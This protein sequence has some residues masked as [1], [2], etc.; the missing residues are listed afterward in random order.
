MTKRIVTLLLAVMFVLS[1]AACGTTTQAPAKIETP[2]ETKTEVKTSEPAPETS[3]PAPDTSTPAP[4]TP[5]PVAVEEPEFDTNEWVNWLIEVD[6]V[7]DEPKYNGFLSGEVYGG[8]KHE[9]AEDPSPWEFWGPEDNKH[10]QMC[11]QFDRDEIDISANVGTEDYEY[12]WEIWY[13]DSEEQGEFKKIVT[14]PWSLY[15]WDSGNIIYRIPTYNEGMNDMALAEGETTHEYEFVFIIY[16]G[17]EISVD[18]MVGWKQD[19]INYS[20]STELYIADA[21]DYGFIA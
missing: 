16:Q 13:R 10:F 18:N 6:G 17:G 20:D 14:A 2:A 5:T 21:K 3:T 1:L 7:A 9:G 4:D 19:W 12:V 15:K 8:I 11:Y